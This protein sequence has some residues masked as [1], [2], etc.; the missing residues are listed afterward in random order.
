M[1]VTG[2]K[3]AELPILIMWDEMRQDTEDTASR[4]YFVLAF[5]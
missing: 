4:S 3:K 1:I 5:F 2:F